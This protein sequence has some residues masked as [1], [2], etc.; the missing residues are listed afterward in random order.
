MKLSSLIVL[1]AVSAAL[2]SPAL[3]KTTLSKGEKLCETAAKAQTPAPKTVRTDADQTKVSDAVLTYKLKIGNAD[4]TNATLI[5]KVDRA[6]DTPTL[7]L[8]Q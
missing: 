3:A 4:D 7:T 5:C 2:A 1:L 8:Q 6:T